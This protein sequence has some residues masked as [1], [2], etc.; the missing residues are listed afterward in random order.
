MTLPSAGKSVPVA[1]IVAAVGGL[2]AIVSAFM[3]WATAKMGTASQSVGGL[4]KNYM[5]G[6]TEI[7][8][9]IVVLALVAAWILNMKIPFIGMLLVVVGVAIL[10]VPLATY[11]TTFYYTPS[12]KDTADAISKAGGSASFGIGFILAAVAG[13]VTI[14][15][16]AMSVLG[17]AGNPPT[18]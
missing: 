7:V 3:D 10:A 1:A 5:N 4:D 13:I 12:L 6:K 18:R 9:G 11:L 8:L 15:G 17:H 14:V 16:G 2:L